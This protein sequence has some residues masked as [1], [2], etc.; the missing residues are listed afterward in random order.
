MGNASSGPILRSWCA[1][2]EPQR[3]PRL[4]SAFRPYG[5]R[6]SDFS[7]RAIVRAR[8]LLVGCG[9][10]AW[11]LSHR[12]TGRAAPQRASLCRAVGT[13]A[14]IEVFGANPVRRKFWSRTKA[15]F[16]A[17]GGGGCRLRGPGVDAAAALGRGRGVGPHEFRP[18]KPRCRGGNSRPA[19][20]RRRR[21]AHRTGPWWTGRTY[22]RAVRRPFSAQGS[23][24]AC[25]PPATHCP[26]GRGC[27]PPPMVPVLAPPHSKASLEDP[28]ADDPD[29][30]SRSRA[31]LGRRIVRRGA[32]R[33]VPLASPSGQEG[34]VTSPPPQG[35]VLALVEGAVEDPSGVARRCGVLPARFPVNRDL[36][37]SIRPP[38][39]GPGK[40]VFEVI[41]GAGKMPAESMKRLGERHSGLGRPPVFVA[42]PRYGRLDPRL[43]VTANPDRAEPGG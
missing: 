4:G 19:R 5:P 17:V 12:R 9:W 39:R 3:T 21:D 23:N 24:A 42:F 35:H 25:P 33:R 43:F 1:V 31:R 29:A 36:S 8:A 34:R 37:C 26:P 11:T 2:L 32:A 6:V 27:E 15:L 18:R 38:D 20:G 28:S 30:L 41:S 16:A 10:V 22:E 13:W 40:L 14:P 7:R